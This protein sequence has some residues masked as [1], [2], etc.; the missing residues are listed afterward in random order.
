[1]ARFSIALDHVKLRQ[2]DQSFLLLTPAG[3]NI[4]SAP[5]RANPRDKP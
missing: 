1:M 3:I 4:I 2:A 5:R